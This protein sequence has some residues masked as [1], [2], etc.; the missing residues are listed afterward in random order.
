MFK[1]QLNSKSLYKRHNEIIELRKKAY[2]AVYQKCINYIQYETDKGELICLFKV[3][4][5]IFGIGAVDIPLCI[6]YIKQKIN[7][8]YNGIIRVDSPTGTDIIFCDWRKIDNP[9]SYL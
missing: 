3:P 4:S 9:K 2:A 7:K 1:H 6:E 8:D 5:F